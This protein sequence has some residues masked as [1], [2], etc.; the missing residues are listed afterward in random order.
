MN[1]EENIN[2]TEEQNTDL[3]IKSKENESN[4]EAKKDSSPEEGSEDKSV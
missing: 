3:K 2:K 4:I 1:I